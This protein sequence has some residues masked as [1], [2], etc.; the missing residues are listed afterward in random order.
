MAFSMSAT[1]LIVED[2]RSLQELLRYTFETDGFLV[3]VAG[4]GDEALEWV[5]RTIPDLIILD[6]MLPGG[7]PGIEVCRILR[8]R[9]KTASIPIVMVTARGEE[10]QKIDAF[11]FGC[12]D[13]VVKPFSVLEL[14]ARVRALLRRSRPEVMSEEITIGPLTL[15]R[16]QKTV[17]YCGEY[18]DLSLTEFRLL[19]RFM[20]NPRQ[21]FTRAQLLDVVWGVSCDI[22]ERAVD[23]HIARLRKTLC[24]KGREDPIRTVRGVGY[25]LKIF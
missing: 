13:Y 5:H 25:G 7:V 11:K 14:V 6:W 16:N 22:D 9:T 24:L 21:V 2:E 8:T 19:E 4:D 18:V 10:Q 15:D 1:L 17:L 20:E 23:A 3:H 12:D